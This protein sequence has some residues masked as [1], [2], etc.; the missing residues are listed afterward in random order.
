MR[1][2]SGPGR[3][4]WHCEWAVHE[5]AQSLVEVAGSTDGDQDSM[6]IW[7]KMSRLLAPWTGAGKSDGEDGGG[8]DGKRPRG[9]MVI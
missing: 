7:K 2:V 4:G 8:G 3:V 5:R 6:L 1:T 9:V